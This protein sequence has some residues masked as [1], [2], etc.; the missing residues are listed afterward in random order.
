ML[1]GS[2]IHFCKV[3]Y[4]VRK[5][6]SFENAILVTYL[7]VLTP[8]YCFKLESHYCSKKI[9]GSVNRLSN[10]IIQFTTKVEMCRSLYRYFHERKRPTLPESKF[11]GFMDGLLFP[12]LFF[13]GMK[14]SPLN[15][16]KYT[17]RSG[18][19]LETFFCG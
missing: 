4:F 5:Y 11:S 16:R 1:K 18:G 15:Q 13:M 12:V 6:F 7:T 3:S 14:I 9:L 17:D 2:E 19:C 8:I 10:E